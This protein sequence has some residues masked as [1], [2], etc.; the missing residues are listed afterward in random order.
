[1]QAAVTAYGIFYKIQQFI[2][3]A[4][5][6]NASFMIWWAFPIAELVAFLVAVILLMRAN[7]KIIKKMRRPAV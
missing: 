6:N 1:M 5:F 2:F 3:F 7:S 4:G